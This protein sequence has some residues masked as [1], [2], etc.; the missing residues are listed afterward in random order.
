[1][2]VCVCVC[3]RDRDRD[4]EIVCV[5]VCVC[6]CLWCICVI[7]NRFDKSFRIKSQKRMQC[8]SKQLF[9]HNFVDPIRRDQCIGKVIFI[10]HVK[11]TN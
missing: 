11:N 4:R 8:K 5:C 3:E 10:K 2:C 7:D 9:S 6:V 1:M